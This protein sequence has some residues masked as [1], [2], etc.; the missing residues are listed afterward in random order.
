MIKDG[1]FQ[2]IWFKTR[3]PLNTISK[4]YLCLQNRWSKT[5]NSDT[6]GR[7]AAWWYHNSW[8]KMADFK[9]LIQ[10]GGFQTRWY[11]IADIRTADSRG[12]QKRWSK[13]A[14]FR[15]DYTRWQTS[16]QLIQEPDFKRDDSRWRISKE[17]IQAGGFQDSWTK[18]ADFRTADPRWRIPEQL[19]QDSW[20]KMAD[21]KRADLPEQKSEGQA[22]QWRPAKEGFSAFSSS[23]P[24]QRE[25][26]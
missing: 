1:K 5:A 7:S 11:K 13:M 17:F 12:F 25:L 26:Q 6:A 23:Y 2:N 24:E 8:S 22:E 18:T 19:T 3:G 15:T 16:E 10:D 9:Q 21:S 14:D 20:Y 4:L